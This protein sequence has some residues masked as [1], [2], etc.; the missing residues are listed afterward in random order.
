M[1]NKISI[2]VKF[3]YLPKINLL[4]LITKKMAKSLLGHHN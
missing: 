1:L 3:L 2:K 4:S